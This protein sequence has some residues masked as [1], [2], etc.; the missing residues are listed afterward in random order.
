LPSG[1]GRPVKRLP[2]V[3]D[4][5]SAGAR[6]EH[7]GVE[8]VQR[9]VECG[10]A[11]LPLPLARGASAV[12]RCAQL[13]AMQGQSVALVGAAAGVEFDLGQRQALQVPAPRLCVDQLD[14]RADRLVQAAR[15]DARFARQQGLWRVGDQRR[16]I[17]PARAGV[18]CR[19]RPRG[20]RGERGLQVD[21]RARGLR[22]GQP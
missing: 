17:E 7:G 16:E 19:E 4:S 22:A 14:V 9:Q 5:V 15:L 10:V 21:L 6:V 2:S 13:E 18:Q 20:E 1:E 11:A 3:P 8:R 12:A